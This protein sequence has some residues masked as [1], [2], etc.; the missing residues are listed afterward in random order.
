MQ[1]YPTLTMLAQTYFNLYR[2]MSKEF[3]SLTRASESRE[4]T[5]WW[6]PSSRASASLSGLVENAVTSQPQA[7]RKRRAIWPKPPMPTTPR[8]RRLR[9]A[10]RRSRPAASST[11]ARRVRSTSNRSVSTNPHS[12]SASRRWTPRPDTC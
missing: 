2:I 12:I 1:I 10:W 6:A 3:A 7:R 11:P 4:L 9:R 5:K 8:C